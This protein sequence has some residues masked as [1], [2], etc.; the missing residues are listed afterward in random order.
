MSREHKAADIEG[1]DSRE[2]LETWDWS[3]GKCFQC[4]TKTDILDRFRVREIME[5][6]TVLD[7]P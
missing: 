5:Q 4:K 2:R 1:R 3:S 7:R 6:S